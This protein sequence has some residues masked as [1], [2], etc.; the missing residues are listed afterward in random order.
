MRKENEK[1]EGEGGP[2][3]EEV[4]GVLGAGEKGHSESGEK[5]HF[6]V[7]KK[8]PLSSITSPEMI[9][10]VSSGIKARYALE[11]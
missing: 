2:N 8:R 7:G 4:Q 1:I 10:Q 3:T 5:G 9:I 11:P 6:L